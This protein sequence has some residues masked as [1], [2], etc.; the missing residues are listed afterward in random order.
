MTFIVW[1]AVALG[2]LVVGHAV[3]RFIHVNWNKSQAAT[4]AQNALIQ[5][6]PQIAHH[7]PAA[8]L[9]N[10]VVASF[11]DSQPALHSGKGTRLPRPEITAI[12][13]LAAARQGSA[14][15][16]KAS[17]IFQLALGEALIRFGHIYTANRLRLSEN[18][19]R[20]FQDAY[21]IY[22]DTSL[23]RIDT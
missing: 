22:H 5:I 17:N 14:S 3:I 23:D 6:A 16:A 18:E 4:Y 15:N 7:I 20:M 9:A 13:A 10:K 12:A 2:T 21:H 8:E 1:A 19:G 11:C